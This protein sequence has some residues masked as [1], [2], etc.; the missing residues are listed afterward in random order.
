MK[1][2]DI[3]KII[4]PWA[5][6]ID[7]PYFISEKEVVKLLEAIPEEEEFVVN[8]NSPGG[9]VYS[10]KAIYN[11]LA[12]RRPKVRTMILGNGASAAAFVS[13]AGEKRIM[14]RNAQ[15]FL[16]EVQSFARGS[17]RDIRKEADANEKIENS[18][19]KIF[20]ERAKISEEEIRALC[21]ETVYLNAEECLKYG[22]IDEIW[23][24]PTPEAAI[25]AENINN[26]L[27]KEMYRMNFRPLSDINADRTAD[28]H[29]INSKI[30]PQHPSIDID[31][32][33]RHKGN[34]T[35][36]I[37]NNF[38][39]NNEEKM[40]EEK[41]TTP[42]PN[43]G[44]AVR[45]AENLLNEKVNSLEKERNSLIAEKQKLEEKLTALEKE[46]KEQQSRSTEYESQ[47]QQLK[48]KN[49]EMQELQV[50]TE[51][52]NIIDNLKAEKKIAPAEIAPDGSYQLNVSGDILTLEDMVSIRKNESLKT[53]SGKTMFDILVGQ[54]QNRQPLGG[55]N[56]SVPAKK[57]NK[58]NGELSW[59]QFKQLSVD[60][61]SNPKIAA[62]IQQ[63]ARD[64][65]LTFAEADNELNQK[66]RQEA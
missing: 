52:K 34:N 63:Y 55:L 60:D 66:I 22:F 64:N 45:T 28:N 26:K 62:Y 17:K 57:E 11:L 36:K 4:S 54:L 59:E 39:T 15:M 43:I 50:R 35:N 42:S 53:G 31:T 48:Q 33:P 21:E 13:Q 6:N 24:P 8:I 25:D 19:I 14:A 49:E 44:E 65:K 29:F 10:G 27:Y 16:H 1:H 3:F 58:S 37:V 20:T 7:D 46:N 32:V 9:S 18:I 47:I 23:D 41:Q 2:I 12:K 56:Q 40:P 51:V 38:P 61:D 5:Y 30:S